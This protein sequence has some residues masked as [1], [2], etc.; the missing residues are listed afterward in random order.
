MSQ[1]G[2]ISVAAESC[3]GC[4]CCVLACSFFTS[5]QK[6]F[7]PSQSKIQVIPGEGDGQFEVAISGDCTLCGICVD[8]C[9]FAVLSQD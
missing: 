3:S 2:M 9:E 8:Y 6:A 7:N 1:G 5:P 4:L